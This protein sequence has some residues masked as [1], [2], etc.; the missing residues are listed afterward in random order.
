MGEVGELTLLAWRPPGRF[1]PVS[2]EGLPMSK[3]AI[4]A[5]DAPTF[6]AETLPDEFMDLIGAAFLAGWTYTAQLIAPTET[7]G[8]SAQLLLC[9]PA[10]DKGNARAD[11]AVRFR[12][13]GGMWELHESLTGRI[14]PKG[15]VQLPVASVMR[16]I[17]ENVQDWALCPIDGE[18]TEKPAAPAKSN[19]KA[20]TQKESKKVPAT[21]AQM[22]F[23]DEDIEG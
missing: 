22:T 13:F 18:I 8:L 20:I 12:L 9:P 3:S 19:I 14:T 1:Q 16:F 21:D 23:S 15:L 4:S 6:Y 7:D 10:T 5:V 2:R 11:I 17:G